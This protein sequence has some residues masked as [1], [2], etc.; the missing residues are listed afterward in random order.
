MSQHRL[1]TVLAAARGGMTVWYICFKDPNTGEV[2]C[3]QIPLLIWRWPWP[4]PDP[5]W[6]WKDWVRF[7][8]PTPDPWIVD[9]PVLATL[10]HLVS[11][12]TDERGV[13]KERVQVAIRDS[14]AEISKS[15]PENVSVDFHEQARGG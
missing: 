12:M 10:D 11:K 2:H 9:L 3:I 15:L 8:R 7:E 6:W 14:I 4:E 1:A 13:V 5:N